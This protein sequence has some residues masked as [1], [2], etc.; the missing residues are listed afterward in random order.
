MDDHSRPRRQDES[1]LY[2]DSSSRY[3]PGQT[4][5]FATNSADR[6]RAPPVANSPTAGRGVGAGPGAY[7]YYNDGGSTAFAAAMP[8]NSMQYASDYTP[9]QQR[10]QNF[11]SYNPNMMYGVPQQT[12]QASVYDSA[13]QFQPRQ[14]AAAMQML[15]EV[16][17]PYFAGE[18]T[19]APA[20]A[21]LHH[22][23]SS[24]SSTAVYQQSPADRTSILQGYSSNIPQNMGSMAQ[25]NASESMEE[26]YGQGSVD[27]PLEA[28][29]TQIKTIFQNIQNG[30][31]GEAS[32][33]LLQVS[34][35]LLSHVGD[36]GKSGMFYIEADFTDFVL[37]G[38]TID[39][40]NL[41]SVRIKL[42]NEF[43]AAW[44]SFMQKQ[45]D[46][47]DEMLHTG[48]TYRE[49]QSMVSLE[50]LEKMA[51]DL[52]KLCDGIE[53]HGLV[54]Y[55]YGVMEEEIMESEY[56]FEISYYASR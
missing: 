8:A 1:P 56:Y 40:A 29:Q 38:L 14:P 41:H 55:Q 48:R 32:R 10:Q 28:Y 26:N 5:N 35:W 46:M 3:P 54:D 16:A 19:S 23:A 53:K 17:A 47:T 31:L 39:D 43:N 30:I 44:T 22:Q 25:G 21:G 9:E 15:S 20:P 49:P 27:E 37:K 7:G 34:E 42:W 6:F 11:A 13:Q 18:P 4:R 2:S 12:Q 52:I 45:K 36:L 33:S 24:S 51:K 50:T